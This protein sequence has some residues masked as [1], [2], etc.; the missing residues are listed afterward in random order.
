MKFA[1]T[2]ILPA[3]TFIELIENS[4]RSGLGLTYYTRLFVM[5]YF[6]QQITAGTNQNPAPRDRLSILYQRNYYQNFVFRRR[7]NKNRPVSHKFIE[8]IHNPFIMDKVYGY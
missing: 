1:K 5:L 2:N 4:N 8:K 7:L 3:M 6:L